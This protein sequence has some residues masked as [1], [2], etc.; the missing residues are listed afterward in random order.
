MRLIHTK[1]HEL[2][3]FVGPQIPAYA[4]LSHTWFN[5]EPTFQDWATRA[6]ASGRGYQKILDTC[7]LAR[8]QGYEYVWVDTVCID[9][10]SSAELSEAINSMFMWYRSAAICYAYLS[11]VLS[12][13]EEGFRHSCY[14]S[15]WFRRGWT[16]QE[17]LAPREVQFYSG[18][19]KLLGTKD[20]LRYDISSITGID[21]KYLSKTIG[22]SYSTGN[23]RLVVK[24]I[25]Y[26]HPV[27]A[28]S[29]AERM[30]WLSRRETTRTEDMAYCML[31]LFDINMP[32]LYG[33]GSRAFI[34]LQEE[35]MK[36]SNDHS[37]F[38]WTRDRD[39]NYRGALCP[40]PSYFKDSSHFIPSQWNT[41]PSPYSMT[42]AGLS[43]TLP[44]LF[45]YTG[46]NF[47]GVLQVESTYG[48]KHFGIT[49]SGDL[50]SG[51]LFRT[52]REP[53]AL[54]DD[55][56]TQKKFNIFI[57]GYHSGDESEEKTVS[58][59]YS[60][61]RLHFG[62]E[63]RYRGLLSYEQ[64]DSSALLVTFEPYESLLSISTFPEDIFNRDQS[65]L[66][67]NTWSNLFASRADPPECALVQIQRRDGVTNSF[68]ISLVKID[69]LWKL[70]SFWISLEEASD[71]RA[72]NMTEAVT[73]L[74]RAIRD[75]EY[76]SR[77]KPPSDACISFTISDEP[78][79][80]DFDCVVV[81]MHVRFSQKP[82]P[83]ST[84]TPR[85]RRRLSRRS[86]RRYM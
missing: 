52:A 8:W 82:S 33:E 2:H 4:I 26:G 73:R 39:H 31:G 32:L 11:D 45:C 68:I 60:E 3:E 75:P 25:S 21:L 47:I 77:L 41:K 14:G 76:A 86:L 67:L 16:L 9:K 71:W 65:I 62:R 17:L 30:S 55:I 58:Y 83:N 43:I 35:I 15:R 85:R 5:Q 1:T 12:P 34:R 79:I 81:H 28:A 70:N 49:M 10:S 42:N 74:Q 63:P 44:L 36:V 29:V 27:A 20:S 7:K 80:R 40:F 78:I 22:S 18:D 64:R 19:W 48:C 23:N 46:N 69:V 61:P 56:P 53:I 84:K 24:S 50:S 66:F 37:L 38:C 59:L 72:G 57:S 6:S 51:R 54:S 13:T